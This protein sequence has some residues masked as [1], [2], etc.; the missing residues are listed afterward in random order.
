VPE[1]KVPGYAVVT[2]PLAG[3][4]EWARQAN[5]TSGGAL[6]NNGTWVF[7]NVRGSDANGKRGVI[8]NHARGVAMDLSFRR[9]EPRR[10]GVNNGRIKALTWLN[11]VLDNW[12]LLGVQCVLDYWPEFGR[13]WRVDRAGTS[14]PKNHAAE[15]W[16]RYTRP[17]LHG[18]PNGDWFHIEIT[19]GM[20]NDP[21]RVKA[22][23]RTAFGKST[24][25]EQAPATVEPTKKKGGKRRAGTDKP[26]SNP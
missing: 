23:F 6:W 2:G 1:Y 17:T 12:E 18:A 24:T 26:E 22:A 25:P 21:E 5:L 11:T 7:R 13:G 10:L 15:A 14:L 20:A 3:T 19:L 8:S 9:I 16:L 4:E